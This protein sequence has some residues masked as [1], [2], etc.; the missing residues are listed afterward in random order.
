[1][2]GFLRKF[3]GNSLPNCSMLDA[4]EG[5]RHRLAR[6]FQLFNGS[7]KSMGYICLGQCCCWIFRR[8]VH[9]VYH[10]YN[11][12]WL[13]NNPGT[14]RLESRSSTSTS[15]TDTNNSCRSSYW[16]NHSSRWLR[17][18]CDYA[19]HFHRCTSVELWRLV[20]HSINSNLKWMGGLLR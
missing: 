4:P 12:C 10:W 19:R 14:V 6:I 7:S 16:S 13:L 2:A 3:R 11:C 9:L 20:R 8:D 18:I 5:L 17:H 1:M 15:T